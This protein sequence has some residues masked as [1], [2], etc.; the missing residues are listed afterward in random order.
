MLDQET[1]IEFEYQDKNGE[2]IASAYNALSAVQM[3]D[4]GLMNEEER[5]QIKTIQF[6][7]I[8]IISESL[9][10]IYEEIFDTSIDDDGDDLV[11]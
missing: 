5:H 6:Q 11:L 10:N 1:E 7:A 2:F 9:N 3:L 4:T 8:N